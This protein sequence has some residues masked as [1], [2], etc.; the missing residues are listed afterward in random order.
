[1]I[2]TQHAVYI[3]PRHYAAPHDPGTDIAHINTQ[4]VPQIVSACINNAIANG[5]YQIPNLQCRFFDTDIG[6]TIKIYGTAYTIQGF[7]CRNTKYGVLLNKVGETPTKIYRWHPLFVLLALKRDVMGSDGGKALYLLQLKN[8]L[9]NDKYTHFQ[10][11]L[12]E[13]TFLAIPLP[14]EAPLRWVPCHI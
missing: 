14:M 3:D 8:I 11:T 9:D 13:Q 4:K 7:K 6:R 5:Q 12:T 2:V 1:M 10:N